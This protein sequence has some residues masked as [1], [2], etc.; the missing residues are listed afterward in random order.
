[1]KFALIVFFILNFSVFGQDSTY[2]KFKYSIRGKVLAGPIS[3]EDDL[4]FTYTIGN[5]FLYK[6]HSIGIDY[7]FFRYNHETD[8][9]KDNPLYDNFIQ[10]KYLLIDYKYLIKKIKWGDLYFNLYD[11]IGGNYKNWFKVFDDSNYAILNSSKTIGTFNEAGLGLGLKKYWRQFGV[12][13]S[14]NYGYRFGQN[15]IQPSMEKEI[16]NRNLFYVRL[17]LFYE[18]RFERKKASYEVFKEHLNR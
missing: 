11:K 5:E 12:D 7:T 17:N 1:M 4:A 8:D 10:R 16:L 18:F 3:P 14:T 9:E 2:L 6:R 15:T 13:I